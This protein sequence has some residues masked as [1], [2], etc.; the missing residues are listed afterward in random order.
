MCLEK[1]SIENANKL[2]DILLN[3]SLK[4]NIKLKFP[5]LDLEIN[6]D[7]ISE[8]YYDD[9]NDRDFMDLLDTTKENSDLCIKINNKYYNL[10]LSLG[11]WGYTYAIPNMHLALYSNCSRFGDYFAQLDL[12][13]CIEDEENV[14]IVKK[15]SKL[16]GEGAIARLNKNLGDDKLAKFGRRF[17][18]INILKA[19]IINYENEG[20]ICINKVKKEDLNNEYMSEEILHNFLCD[21]INYAFT[22]EELI[23]VY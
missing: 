8:N 5:S 22:I 23:N 14:Y 19:D 17:L 21:F 18:L 1:I 3:S 9:Y 7:N 6:I 15:I 10:R 13:Q 2:K 12:S 11:E 20:W 16:S 4:R